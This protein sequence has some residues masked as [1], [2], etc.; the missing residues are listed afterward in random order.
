MPNGTPVLSPDELRALRAYAERRRADL[1]A[2]QLG[3]ARVRLEAAGLVRD[4]PRSESPM[5]VAVT[6]RGREVLAEQVE[7]E[8]LEPLPGAEAIIPTSAASPSP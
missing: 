1:T 5:Y 7:A 3:R 4:C 8:R 6:A 2:T